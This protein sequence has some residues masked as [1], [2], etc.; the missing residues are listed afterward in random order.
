MTK[1]HSLSWVPRL[2]FVVSVTNWLDQ[3]KQAPWKSLCQENLEL[4][5]TP[6][7]QRSIAHSAQAKP[8]PLTLRDFFG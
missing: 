8:K 6:S 2:E 3:S 4:S 7:F 1:W 5:D